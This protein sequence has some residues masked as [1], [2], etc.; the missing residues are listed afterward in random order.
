MR[1]FSPVACGGSFAAAA[2][3]K[4]PSDDL[5]QCAATIGDSTSG[6]FSVTWKCRTPTL[7]PRSAMFGGMTS[8][9][10]TVAGRISGPRH[11]CGESPP[12]IAAS[13]ILNHSRKPVPPAR[14]HRPRLHP[15]RN[16]L[17]IARPRNARHADV[18]PVAAVRPLRQTR[19]A[20]SAFASRAA[21]DERE[22][23]G[24]GPPDVE[25]DVVDQEE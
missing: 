4:S 7:T 21:T 24:S 9:S 20:R 11:G 3:S 18:P 16:D 25:Q 2:L 10:S 14:V 8:V 13:I 22:L 23:V 5:T 17:I 15:T 12:G 1:E 6:V 19:R